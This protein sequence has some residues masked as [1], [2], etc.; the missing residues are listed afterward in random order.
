MDKNRYGVH[1][2]HCCADHGCKY[3]DKDCP[4]ALGEIKQ[5]Y[6]CEYCGDEKE[7]FKWH[8]KEVLSSPGRFARYLAK[9]VE[10]TDNDQ[11]KEA[12]QAALTK[13]NQG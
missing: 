7:Q 3:G 8:A 5:A 2:T 6:E 12:I 9:Y 10:H 4:V 13:L 11:V 1:E